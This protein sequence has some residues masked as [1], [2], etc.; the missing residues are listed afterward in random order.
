MRAVLKVGRGTGCGLR[1]GP[2][3][4]EL[5]LMRAET[6]QHELLRAE[7][8]MSSCGIAPARGTG[9]TQRASASTGLRPPALRNGHTAALGL[10]G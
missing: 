7:L 3:L 8:G 2:T 6:K 4:V 10:F 9:V 1:T 5:R